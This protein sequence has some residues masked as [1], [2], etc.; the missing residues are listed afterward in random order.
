MYN[1]EINQDELRLHYCEMFML[2]RMPF[3]TTFAII[4]VEQIKTFLHIRVL[5]K[6]PLY[7]GS[8]PPKQVPFGE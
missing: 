4:F 3:A 6:S 5:H 8:H 1:D 7:P 2:K